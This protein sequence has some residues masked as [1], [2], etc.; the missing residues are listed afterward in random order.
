MNTEK[1][2]QDKCSEISGTPFD[3]FKAGYNF[4]QVKWHKFP[5]ELPEDLHNVLTVAL[6]HDRT[7]KFYHTFTFG[8]KSTVELLLSRRHRPSMAFLQWNAEKYFDVVAWCEL[9]EYEG[10][11]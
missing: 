4:A 9:P 7:K 2:L 10:S 5:D 8:E 3:Y 1:E 11:I 6:N